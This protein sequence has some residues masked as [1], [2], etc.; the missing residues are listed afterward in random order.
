MF[1]KPA[2]EKPKRKEYPNLDHLDRKKPGAV[3]INA[4]CELPLGL[5]GLFSSSMAQQE[6]MMNEFAK[7]NHVEV[8]DWF[9]NKNDLKERDQKNGGLRTYVISDINSKNK[10]SESYQICTG[11]ALTAQ[12]R[13]QK[14]NY[15]SIMSHSNPLEVLRHKWTNGYFSD[16]EDSISELK[17]LAEPGT[18]DAVI[19][20]GMAKSLHNTLEENGK[21]QNYIDSI[22]KLGKFV[23]EQ[24][25][26]DVRVALAPSDN[27]SGVH[28]Y[29]T[30]AEDT[31][32]DKKHTL[33]FI[34]PQQMDPLNNSSFQWFSIKELSKLFGNQP[35]EKVSKK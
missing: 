29:L 8:V 28:A 26:F 9:A 12:K 4:V 27:P 11:L 30:L 18:I 23:S 10:L 17:E 13:D 2:Q 34:R 7:K 25:G 1:D 22:L 33:N 14:G 32:N 15:M 16:L 5:D 19:Y 24:L 20:G 21:R 3:P 35:D 6:S 31:N